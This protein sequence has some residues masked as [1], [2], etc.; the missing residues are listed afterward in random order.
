MQNLLRPYN[1]PNN[2][3]IGF[4]LKQLANEYPEQ[5]HD[6]MLGYHHFASGMKVLNR[7]ILNLQNTYGKLNVL[8]YYM[9]ELRTKKA[10]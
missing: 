1:L 4:R 3:Y 8:S 6:A 7:H 2:Y 9:A 5:F 10:I